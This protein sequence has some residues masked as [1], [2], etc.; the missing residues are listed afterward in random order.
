MRA[1]QNRSR[2]TFDMPS[3]SIDDAGGQSVVWATQ[4]TVWAWIHPLTGRERSRSDQ[5][6]A[7]LDTRIRIRWDPRTARINATWR[8][9]DAAGTVYNIAAPPIQAD[10]RRREIE[11]LCN[12]GMN[13][14]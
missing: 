8:C 12:S 10:L 11:L 1:G 3:V 9:R 13:Q 4:F 6:I 5:I 14:G 2:L 7:D